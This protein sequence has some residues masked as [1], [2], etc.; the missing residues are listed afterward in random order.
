MRGCLLSCSVAALGDS[1]PPPNESVHCFVSSFSLRVGIKRKGGRLPNL[2]ALL[3]GGL[4]RVRAFAVLVMLAGL[5]AGWGA[6]DCSK[7][8]NPVRACRQEGATR[9]RQGDAAH[10]QAPSLCNV[11]RTAAAR[12]LRRVLASGKGKEPAAG[13]NGALRARTHASF[14]NAVKLQRRVT[15]RAPEGC[16][17]Q[18][19]FGDPYE[20]IA[21]FCVLHCA[22]EH[23]CVRGRHCE[24]LEGCR[25]RAL[26]LERGVYL[27]GKHLCVDRTQP[28]LDAPVRL[29]ADT[30][31]ASTLQSMA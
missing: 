3:W 8:S 1:T 11:S 14:P 23:V 20:R 30:V 25:Q 22:P 9:S 12:L 15:C 31:S 19:S 7:R 16:T 2:F 24:H 10:L 27:C 29:A 26:Y 5:T 6:S 18:P 13:S 4:M 17:R 21:K 28:Q